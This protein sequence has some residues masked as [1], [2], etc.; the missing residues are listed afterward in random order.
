MQEQILQFWLLL[1]LLSLFGKKSNQNPRLPQ[2]IHTNFSQGLLNLI[3]NSFVLFLLFIG[4]LQ[5]QDYTLIYTIHTH[6]SIQQQ[7]Y[8]LYLYLSC[9][10]QNY[11]YTHQHPDINVHMC[12]YLIHMCIGMHMY[13]YILKS[14][15]V[16][17]VE[18]TKD[19][20]N[21]YFWLCFYYF[22]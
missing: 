11:A 19:T 12:V 22:I 9:K 7:I 6:I 13:M 2:N 3:Y 8:I 21:Q 20:K 1:L 18:R 10:L 4:H 14:F 16:H 15:T 17:I 5:L